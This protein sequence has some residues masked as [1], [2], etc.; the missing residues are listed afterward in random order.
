MVVEAS[1]THC[2]IGLVLSR[3][4]LAVLVCSMRQEPMVTLSAPVLLNF[5]DD[6]DFAFSFFG[7]RWPTLLFN[8]RFTTNSLLVVV[9]FPFDFGIASA[10][11]LL[12]FGAVLCEV[13]CLAAVEAG[14]FSLLLVRLCMTA[15]P[16]LSIC[17]LA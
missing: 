5:I 14:A 9:M 11:F 3:F 17:W 7:W 2:C 8:L 4:L 15:L 12:W 1:S 6:L 10:S 13:P 16:L